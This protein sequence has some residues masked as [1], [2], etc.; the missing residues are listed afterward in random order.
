[1]TMKFSGVSSPVW[2]KRIS[3][4]TKIIFLVDTFLI[5]NLSRLNHA[6]SAGKGTPSFTSAPLSV[7]FTTL[8]KSF[9]SDCSSCTLLASAAESCAKQKERE[10]NTKQA[11]AAHRLIIAIT[12]CR[13]KSLAGPSNCSGFQGIS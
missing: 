8:T 3:P 13:A 5:T 2:G 4:S 11:V 10:A 9:G 12:S 6:S 7:T 1:M